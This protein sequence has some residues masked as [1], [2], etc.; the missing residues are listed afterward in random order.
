MSTD[1]S[2]VIRWAGGAVPDAPLLPYKTADGSFC[3]VSRRVIAA[4]DSAAFEVRYFEIEAGGHSTFER[5]DHV[6]VVLCMRGSGSARL[7][8]ETCDVNPG[9]VVIVAPGDPHQFRNPGIEPFGFFCVVD[10]NRDRPVAIE[11]D[12]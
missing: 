7:G 8:D 1:V 6:H 9:D 5:H 10:R 11:G 2:H 3:A 4:P 12:A